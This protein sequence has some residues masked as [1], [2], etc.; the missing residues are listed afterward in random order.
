VAKMGAFGL[1]SVRERLEY[2]GGRFEIDSA[3]GCGCRIT[4]LAPLK[5][6]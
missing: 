4:M 6:A 2:L 3:P 5:E 1:F